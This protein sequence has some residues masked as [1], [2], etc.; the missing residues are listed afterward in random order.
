MV[1]LPT[2]DFTGLGPKHTSLVADVATSVPTPL[3]QTTLDEAK[4]HVAHFHL[5]HFGVRV[6]RIRDRRLFRS[7]LGA[8]ALVVG[9]R[10]GRAHGRLA[11]AR[12]LAYVGA[13]VGGIGWERFANVFDACA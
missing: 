11:S 3:K 10:D 1:K 13:R 12:L 6:V 5:A 8:F 2:V 7:L 9:R 4:Q